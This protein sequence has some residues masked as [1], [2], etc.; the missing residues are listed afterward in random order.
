MKKAAAC[1][2]SDSAK[3]DMIEG[4]EVRKISWRSGLELELELLLLLQTLLRLLT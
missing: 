1:V 3:G 2:S 4:A